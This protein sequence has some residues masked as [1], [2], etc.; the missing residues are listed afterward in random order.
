MAA[1]LDAEAL[2]QPL[3]RDCARGDAY[4]RLARRLPSSA[5]IVAYPV[6]LPIRVIGVARAKRVGDVRVVLAPRVLV[7]DQKCDRRA[8]RAT[9]EHAGQYFDGVGLTPLAHVPRRARPAP[10]QIALDIG[11]R[12][13]ESRWTAV[14]DAADRGSMG[15]AER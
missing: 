7:A 10:V 14:Y 4:G 12:E 15:F 1:N 13:L 11:F 2:A 5:A 8:G 9:L 6:F 3:A